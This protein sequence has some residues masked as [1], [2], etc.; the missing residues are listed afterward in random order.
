MKYDKVLLAHGSGGKLSHD[1]VREVFLPA[2]GNKALNRL[3][4]RAEVSV[5]G[6]RLAF[7]T[8]S[9]VVNPIFFAG[10]DIGKLAVCGT[11]NDLAM[12]GAQP[13]YLS[14]GFIIEEGLEMDIL[15]KIVASMQAAAREAGVDIVTGDTKVVEKGSADKL[16]INTAGIGIVEEGI[17]I[18]GHNAKPGDKVIIN[19]FIGDHG[20]AVMAERQGL[21]F[22]SGIASDCAPLNKLVAK[23]LEVTRDIRVLRDPTRGGVATTLNEIAGQSS[24]G[25]VLHEKELPIRDE[26]MAACEFLGF[27]P[28][29]VAN[30]GKLLAIVPAEKAE[31]ILAV[32]QGEKYGENAA[33]IGEVVSD[34]P[35]KVV[36]KTAVGG[37]RIVDMLVGEQLPRIC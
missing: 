12:G 16:F 22:Q 18:S 2:F 28:L 34:H 11:V 30:E 4:D 17:H 32:M 13:L 23:M 10:G 33:I 15:K 25:I 1:L 20:M 24:V 5:P 35:G 19:G 3:D 8:D 7:S 31:D 9:F 6:T 29:Y 37:R 14:V 21:S 27:D 36:L 26:V